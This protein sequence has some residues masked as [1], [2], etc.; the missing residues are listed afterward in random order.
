MTL[1]PSKLGFSAETLEDIAQIK[2]KSPTMARL[3]EM[4][5]GNEM[6]NF[7]KRMVIEEKHNPLDVASCIVEGAAANAISPFLGLAAEGKLP[8]IVSAM[9]IR[10]LQKD[11]NAFFDKA[12]V[13]LLDGT[14]TD[15][16]RRKKK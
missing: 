16:L 11:A 9:M 1:D 5:F 15:E 2:E 3:I 8:V 13:G 4:G 7:I 12:L 10:T 14:L 6:M